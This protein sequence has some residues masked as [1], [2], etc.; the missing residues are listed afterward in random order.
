MRSLDLLFSATCT[1]EA[2]V[3]LSR[4]IYPTPRGV[5]G[6]SADACNSESENLRVIVRLRDCERNGT[7]PCVVKRSAGGSARLRLPLDKASRCA[8]HNACCAQ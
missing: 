2:E 3:T 8:S 6:E 4:L 5:Q 1:C 7:E